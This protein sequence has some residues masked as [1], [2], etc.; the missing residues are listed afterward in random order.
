MKKIFFF[1]IDGTLAVK[2]VIPKG[3]IEALKKLKEKGCLVFICT[4]RAPFYA[5]KLF[6]NLVSGYV[7]CNG[8]YIIYQ[9]KKLHGEAFSENDLKYYQ[10]K[11]SKLN[12]GALFI[13]D[14]NAYAFNF[15]QKQLEKVKKEYGS[16]KI[17]LQKFNQHFYTFDLF[18]QNTDQ[19]NQLISEF[20]DDL[21]INDHGGTGSCDCS[22]ICF[23]KGSV[24]AY[25][26]KY[27][28]IA[29]DQAYA[30]GDGYNDQAMFKA[31]GHGIAMGNAVDVLKKKAT[32]IT[33]TIENDGILKAL[34]HEKII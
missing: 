24:I 18:Y 16:D 26:L 32:Y 23:D 30:F 11:I 34:Y 6:K 3:N 31:V 33:D 10:N 28:K 17:I 1:D 13:A 9:D 25:L 14:K 4:G 7:T 5:K 20:K 19:L 2:G 15:N 21:V 22:T 29:K 8:R 27:F 12:C